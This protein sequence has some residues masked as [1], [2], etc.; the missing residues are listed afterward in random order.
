MLQKPKRKLK[1]L[2]IDDSEV[3]RTVILSMLRG[4]F[5]TFASNTE[6]GIS[7]YELL[8]PEIVFLD[9]NLPDINGMDALKMI[10]QYD[11]NAYVIM[12]T[13]SSQ[14]PDVI[15]AMKLGA[16]G[17]MVKPF[18]KK[19]MVMALERYMVQHQDQVS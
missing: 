7:Q 1:I 5:C 8:H 14:L 9:I 15:E 12:L 19:K 2:T 11:N 4:H 18:S 16:S 3:I 10:R 17:Y 6:K 13:G